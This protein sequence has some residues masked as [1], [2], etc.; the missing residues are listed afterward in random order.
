MAAYYPLFDD[1]IT[2]GPIGPTGIGFK[3]TDDGNYDME[4]KKLKN[5]D[6]PVDINDASTKSYVDSIELNLKSKMVELQK[7]SLIHSEHGDFDARGKIIGN[8]KDPIK[9]LNVVNKQYLENNALTLSQTN[10]VH[11]EYFYDLK[12]IPLKHLSNPQDKNDAVPK[13]YVDR[14][15]KINDK[16]PDNQLMRNSE[17]LYVEC[18]DFWATIKEDFQTFEGPGLKNV[19]FNLMSSKLLDE[20][21]KLSTDMYM[22]ITIYLKFDTLYILNKPDPYIELKLNDKVILCGGIYGKDSVSCFT[23]GK[24]NDVISLEIL[25]ETNPEYDYKHIKTFM[26]IEKLDFNL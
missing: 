25:Q 9:N 11:P 12:S 22:K 7:R 5:V 2:E 3:L 14:K 13:Q 4:K 24:Q 18:K 6:E 19:N 1:E 17:G 16:K 15:T 23:E 10:T 20:N 8:V 26:H 21:L